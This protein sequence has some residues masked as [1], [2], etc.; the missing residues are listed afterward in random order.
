MQSDDCG[1]ALRA[2]DFGLGRTK[3]KGYYVSE[4]CGGVGTPEWTAPEVS[5]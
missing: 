1:V 2:G 4:G 5:G 3:Q